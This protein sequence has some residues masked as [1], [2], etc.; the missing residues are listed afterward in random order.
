MFSSALQK[1]LVG[2]ASLVA[3]YF[4][5][6]L[7]RSVSQPKSPIVLGE[8]NSFDPVV[9]AWVKLGDLSTQSRRDMLL[10]IAD[11]TG[12][13]LDVDW[14]ILSDQP[15]NGLGEFQ[16]T[17]EEALEE[18]L[19]GYPFYLRQWRVEDGTF[20]LRN[21]MPAQD[22]GSVVRVYELLPTFNRLRNEDP[23]GDW[24][25]YD[26]ERFFRPLT[27]DEL[28]TISEENVSVDIGHLIRQQIDPDI[29]TPEGNWITPE[30]GFI[31]VRAAPD[32][33]ARVERFIRL[34]NGE[35]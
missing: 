33:Q 32:V 10:K 15:I 24:I 21:P 31:I 29:W 17:V 14:S 20:I 6:L 28:T 26:S 23:Y 8:Y 2:V 25:E 22:K 16:G 1:T 18:L 13:K 11:Q 30:P 27:A 12:L 5:P 34:L 19:P 3:G 9:N 7:H 4:L 35:Q